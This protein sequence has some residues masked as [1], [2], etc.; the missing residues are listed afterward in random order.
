MLTSFAACSRPYDER[1]WH[2][3]TAPVPFN[4][5][6]RRR[7]SRPIESGSRKEG[8][9]RVES[10]SITDP[11]EFRTH[12][13]PAPTSSTRRTTPIVMNRIVDEPPFLAEPNGS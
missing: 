5:F 7:D 13:V 9:A 12:V 10:I 6:P 8:A 11:P 1:A 3:G 2:W 4:A